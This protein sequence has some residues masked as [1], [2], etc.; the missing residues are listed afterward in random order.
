MQITDK[1]ESEYAG[2]TKECILEQDKDQI[3][4][5]N[6]KKLPTPW[7]LSYLRVQIDLN[8]F[9]LMYNKNNNQANNINRASKENQS[10]LG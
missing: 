6:I 5:Q 9:C 2:R 10:D 7:F 1:G 4:G 3:R 8:M